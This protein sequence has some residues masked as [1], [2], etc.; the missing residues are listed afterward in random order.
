MEARIERHR[1]ANGEGCLGKADDLEQ[2]F[3]LRAQDKLAPALVRA[4][5]T[6]ADAHGCNKDKVNEAF[7]CANAMERW[8][9]RKFPD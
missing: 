1:A 8:H 6:L 7:E 9:T 5:A 4:W 2:V 3:I